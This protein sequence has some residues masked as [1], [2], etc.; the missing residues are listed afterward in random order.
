MTDYNYQYN[1]YTIDIVKIMYHGNKDY[2]LN[3][4]NACI[5]SENEFS[6]VN[7]AKQRLLQSTNHM[8]EQILLLI[9]LSHD[10]L[11]KVDI[12]SPYLY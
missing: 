4:V 6:L 3:K 9:Y 10:W 11:L 5:K 8:Q 1:L 12:D 7:E 2:S